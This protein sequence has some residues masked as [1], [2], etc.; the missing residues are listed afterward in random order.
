MRERNA[1]IIRSRGERRR[2]G[3][4]LGVNMDITGQRFH[5]YTSSRGRA[6]CDSH[7]ESEQAMRC[8]RRRSCVAFLVVLLAGASVRADK[9]VLV[10]GGGDQAPPAPATAA[11][12]I[13]PFGADFD[14]AGNLYIVE[15]TGQRVHKM[16]AKGLLTTIA[17]TTSQKGDAGDGGPAAKALFNGMHSLAI[18]P[19]GAIYLADTW[20][21]C[22]RKLDPM[23]N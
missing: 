7:Q 14:R 15:L 20:N 18:A 16:D 23:T 4:R 1:L 19:D 21:N 9:L 2:S 13:A 11:K 10:A 17:G 5:C 3:F 8:T 6:K 12:L 22:V